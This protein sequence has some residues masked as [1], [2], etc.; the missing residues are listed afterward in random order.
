MTDRY[1]L[2]DKQIYGSDVDDDDMDAIL[3]AADK[4]THFAHDDSDQGAS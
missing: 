3:E 4:I 2:R 1:P